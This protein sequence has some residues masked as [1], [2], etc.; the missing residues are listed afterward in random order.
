MKLTDRMKE[1]YL[2]EKFFDQ[3]GTYYYDPNR[4][5]TDSLADDLEYE[6]ELTKGCGFI[7]LSWAVIAALFIYI[8]CKFF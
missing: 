4:P 7:I 3:H 1:Y 5:A 6:Q 2:Q 8:T